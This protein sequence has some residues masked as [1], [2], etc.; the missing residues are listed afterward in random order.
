MTP[1]QEALVEK[2]KKNLVNCPWY[3]FSEWELDFLYNVWVPECEIEEWRDES[4]EEKKLKMAAG[5]A[6][7]FRNW[8]FYPT[9]ITER[10]HNLDA[11]LARLE[12][13]FASNTW[14]S[15]LWN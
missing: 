10:D 3:S 13:V 12:R 2:I 1:N 9:P 6:G 7:F 11:R 14:R 4:A 15:R 5:R 8:N